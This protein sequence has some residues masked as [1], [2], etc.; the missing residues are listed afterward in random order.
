MFSF[1]LSLCLKFFLSLCH[2]QTVSVNLIN[3]ADFSYQD[4]CSY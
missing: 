4:Y 3:Q 1:I 2:V